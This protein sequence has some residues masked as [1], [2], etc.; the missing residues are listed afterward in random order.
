[1]SIVLVGISLFNID[2]NRLRKRKLVVRWGL[3]FVIVMVVFVNYIL[4]SGG[5][6]DIGNFIYMQF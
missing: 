4:Q 1:M 6:G 5:N 2:I 3:Y